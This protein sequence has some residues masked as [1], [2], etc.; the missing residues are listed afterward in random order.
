MPTRVGAPCACC[1][2]VTGVKPARASSRPLAAHVEF[3]LPALAAAAR[4]GFEFERAGL[5]DAGVQAHRHH[6]AG[7]AALGRQRGGDRRELLQ[8]VGRPGVEQRADAVLAPHRR[9]E[10]AEV[11]R[12]ADDQARVRAPAA[13]LRCLL[14]CRTAPR[15]GP[16]PAARCRAPRASTIRRRRSTRTRCRRGCARRGRAARSRSRRR[17]GRPRGRGRRRSAAAPARRLR[18]RARR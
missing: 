17:R 11:H 13:R 4:H 9:G 5:G 18:R 7:A 8:L 12:L 14:P 6:V 15:T 3:D 16:A 1:A 10:E 2:P